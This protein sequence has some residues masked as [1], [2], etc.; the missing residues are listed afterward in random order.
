MHAKAILEIP[1]ARLTAVCSRDF[2]K[3]S[4]FAALYGAKAYAD[5][6]DMVNDPGV[7]MVIICTPHPLHAGPAVLAARAGRHVLVEKPLASSLKDCDDILRAAEENG[8]QLGMVSQR[9]FYPP[10]Q[11]VREAIDTGKIGRPVLGMVQ[12]L[13]W[14]DEKYYRSDPWRGSWQGEGGGVL[15]NQA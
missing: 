7:E 1:E 6:A 3:A 11:R 10:V 5:A 8:V 15:V 4:E 13:G 14:R 9:R 2:G 12:M